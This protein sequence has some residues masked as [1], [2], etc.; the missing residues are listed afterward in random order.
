MG[1]NFCK[2]DEE[3][4]CAVCHRIVPKLGYTSRDHCPYC[5]HSIHVDEVPGDRAC[6]CLGILDPVGLEIKGGKN[7]IVFRCRK[8]G[9]K[10]INVAAKDDD[11]DLIIALSSNPL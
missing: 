6:E 11:E 1:G 3:F 9:M 8:C 4:E 7:R 5:L 10:K 2:L